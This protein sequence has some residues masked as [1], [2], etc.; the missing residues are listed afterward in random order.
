[1]EEAS[2]SRKMANTTYDLE[3]ST[4]KYNH[5]KTM[6]ASCYILLIAK[7]LKYDFEILLLLEKELKPE[8]F[9]LFKFCFIWQIIWSYWAFLSISMVLD[10]QKIYM[11][12]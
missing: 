11:E 2:S 10:F 9:F 5:T 6:K 7:N 12:L 8:V 1:M 4:Y 3:K